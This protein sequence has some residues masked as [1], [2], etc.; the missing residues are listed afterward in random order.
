V[1]LRIINHKPSVDNPDRTTAVI[2]FWTIDT[3]DDDIWTT[4][5]GNKGE[6]G[7]KIY[8]QGPDYAG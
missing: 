6:E 3:S 2:P 1:C 4:P 5:L 7:L 8:V